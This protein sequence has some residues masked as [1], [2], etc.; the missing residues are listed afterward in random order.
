[1]QQVAYKVERVLLPA[2]A[3]AVCLGAGCSSRVAPP[4]LPPPEYEEPRPFS[5]PT[6]PTEAEPVPEPAPVP[7][8][9]ADAPVAPDVDAGAEAPSSDAGAEAR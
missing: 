1:M 3:L 4:N 7:T 6:V 5:P 2:L 9:A 8:P